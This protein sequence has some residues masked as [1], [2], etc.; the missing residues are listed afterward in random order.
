VITGGDGVDTAI[1]PTEPDIIYAQSQ[2]GWLVRYEK[3]SGE[4][5]NIRPVEPIGE[6]AYRCNWDASILISPHNNSR[7]YFC[8]NKVFRSENN[9]DSWNTISEDLS[10]G[11]DRNALK[12]MGKVWSMDA[13]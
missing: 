13:V 1:D 3:K 10:S 7:I 11:V 6:P 9:G 5:V 12:V 2:Y 8:A 4:K